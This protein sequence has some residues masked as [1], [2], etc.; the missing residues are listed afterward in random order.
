MKK[1]YSFIEGIVVLCS[2]SL[3][4]KY[5]LPSLILVF[6]GL[7]IYFKVDESRFAAD[8]A[9]SSINA[10]QEQSVIAELNKQ[11][12]R[13]AET[14]GELEKSIAVKSKPS[15][16]VLKSLDNTQEDLQNMLNDFSNPVL[17]KKLTP[18][19]VALEQQVTSQKKIYFELQQ[20]NISNA[21]TLMQAVNN[22][23][24]TQAKTVVGQFGAATDNAELLSNKS[25]ML[26]Y[27][28]MMV[29]VLGVACF[30][31]IWIYLYIKGRQSKESEKQVKTSAAVKENFLANMS[32][33]IRTPLN[34]ILGFTSILKNTKLE[35]EQK[36]YVD[37]IRSSGDNLLSIVNDILDLSKIEAGMLRIEKA[38]FRIREIITA[39]EA[40]LRPKAEEKNLKLVVKVDEET[41]EMINGD[42]VR[43]SQILINLVNNAIKFTNDGGVYL[44]VTPVA[45]SGDTVSLEFLVRDT[46]IGI[47]KE[48]QKNIFDRFEQAEASTTRRFGGTG[49]GLSIVKNLIDLQNG[50]IELESHEGAGSSFTV[51][52]PYAETKEKQ[53]ISEPQKLILNPNQMRTDMKILIAEDNVMNQ[54]LISHLMKSWSFNFDLV[55]NGAQ[56][57]ESIRKN[58]YDL[59]LMDI[60]MPEMDGYT[61]TSQIRSVLRSDVPIIAMTAHAMTGEKEKCLKAGMDN[62]ISKPLNEDALHNLILLYAPESKTATTKATEPEVENVG[63]KVIDLNI[64]NKYSGG[65]AEFRKEMIKEFINTLPP[66]IHLLEDAIKQGDYSKIKMI[67]HDMKTTIHV[68]GLTILI[69]HLLQEIEKYAYSNTGLSNINNIFSDVK[70]VCMQAVQEANRLVA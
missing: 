1:S 14:A 21:A 40:M 24:Q 17:V 61:A 6:A 35:E 55:F 41:P 36:E 27:Y 16:D 56:A 58:H 20:S 26:G 7:F 38:P 68:M 25:D 67:A 42:A 12:T 57:V 33:E 18:L 15:P 60:Q 54:R 3:I 30:L 9:K 51:I 65:D 66:S 59:I 32:H 34:A 29:I 28:N 22:E 46:G 52:I 43:L 23:T 53:S 39:V 2:R 69:G 13:L 62:Y 37:I 19:A 8:L 10:Q 48:K 49:L 63:G 31:L 64:I 11:E 45:K 70:D 44:R 4:R 50:T 47:P 5:I